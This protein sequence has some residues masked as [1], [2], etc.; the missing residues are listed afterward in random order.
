MRNHTGRIAAAIL[1]AALGGWVVS[2]CTNTGTPT[3]QAQHVIDVL[4]ERD[5]ALQP[6]IVPVV[7]VASPAAGPAAPVVGAAL[8]A[9][10]VLVHPAVVAACA[11]YHSKPAAVVD[12][13][14]PG[15]K[16]VAPVTVAVPAAKP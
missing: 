12:A 7:A 5:A 4:C 1:F 6:L 16:V 8:A 13:A 14:P 9:D 15:A 10:Q 11:Q 2:G 3:P